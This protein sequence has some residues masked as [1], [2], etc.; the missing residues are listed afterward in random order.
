MN[1]MGTIDKLDITEICLHISNVLEQLADITLEADVDNW[2]F[3]LDYSD[4]DLLNALMIFF[5]VA[6]N[7]AI[8]DGQFKTPDD[9]EAKMH[10]LR[11]AIKDCYGFN[12]QELTEKVLKK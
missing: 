8:K 5:H 2:S 9:A 7:K 3:F 6:N 12:S 1:D 4:R 10:N 11:I